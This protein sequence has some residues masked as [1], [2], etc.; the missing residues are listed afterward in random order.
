M[1]VVVWNLD[2]RYRPELEVEIDIVLG[3]DEIP[4]AY[5]ACLRPDLEVDIRIANELDDDPWFVDDDAI[6]ESQAS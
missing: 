2:A 4:G 5:H 6:P 1:D 3:A